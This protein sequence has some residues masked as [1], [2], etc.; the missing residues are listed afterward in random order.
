[1]GQFCAKARDR[2]EVKTVKYLTKMTYSLV[3]KAVINNNYHKVIS[4]MKKGNVRCQE[5]P[6]KEALHVCKPVVANSWYQGQ[7]QLQTTLLASTMF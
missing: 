2:V 3:G 1:M 6:W 4:V 5:S 7:I